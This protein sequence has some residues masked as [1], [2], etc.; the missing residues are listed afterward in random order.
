MHKTIKVLLAEDEISLGQIIKESLETQNMAV[1]FHTN[2]ETALLAYKKTKPDILILDIMMP[3][4]DGLILAKDIRNIDSATPIIFLTAK[5]QTKDVVA[6]FNVGCND[7]IRKPFSIEELIVRIYALLG[8]SFKENKITEPIHVGAYIF[9]SNKQT[10]VTTNKG[11]S[12]THKESSLLQ[13][14]IEHKN[15]VLNRTE[16]LQKLWGNDDFFAGRSLD[17]FITKLRNKLKLDTNITIINVRGIG[18]KIT[19]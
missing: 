11:Y 17:V 9:D 14:L 2:G 3:V 10:L 5:S 12:L 13:M 16:I 8:K 7:Y 18:Y 1:D 6:G 19:F 4:K 15:E